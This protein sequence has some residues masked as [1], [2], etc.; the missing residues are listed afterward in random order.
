MDEQAIKVE[1]SCVHNLKAVSCILPHN[2]LYCLTGVSG[3]GK[4]SF[5]FDTIFVEGQRRYIESLSHQAKRLFSSLPKPD[6]ESITGLT[7]TIS[8]EQKSISHNPR[9]TVGTLTEIYDYLRILFAR[10]AI[11]YC[12]ISL[13]PVSHQTKDQVLLH[14]Y[15]FLQGEKIIILAPWAKEKRGLLEDDFEQIQKKGF[16]RVRIDGKVT[17]IDEIHDLDAEKEHDLEVVIDRIQVNEENKN[18]ALESFSTALEFGNGMM[19]LVNLESEEEHLFSIHA[20]SQKSGKSYPPLEPIDFSFN[21][22]S[23]MCPECHGLGQKQLFILDKVLDETASIRED[24][25][26]IASSYNTVRYKNIYDNLATLYNFSVDTPFSSLPDL[27]K[28]V[29][30]Y[31]TEKKWTRMLFIH[32]QTGATWH[33]TVQWKGVLNE[34][35]QRYQDAT[36]DLFKQKFERLMTLSSCPKCLGSR[37]KPYPACAQFFG[38]TVQEIVSMTIGEA[39]LFFSSLTLIGDQKLLAQ[40]I[41]DNVSSRLHFLQ[42]VGLSYITL[43]RSSPTLSGGEA[44]RVR[45]ASHIGSG[46]M[47][48]TYVLDEPSIGL[49]PHDNKKLIDSLLQLRDKGNTVIVVEHDEETMRA[50]DILIEFGPNAGENG[51]EIL[52]FGEIQELQKTPFS[53]T[54]EY[55][56]GK[57]IGLQRERSIQ[58]SSKQISLIGASHNNLKKVTVSIPL[59]FFVGVTGLSGSGKSSLF[60]ETL[61]PALSNHLNGSELRVGAYQSIQ[62]IESLSKIIQI[63]QSPIGRTPRSN[64]ATYSKVFDDIR[65][66]FASLPE[67]KA[68]GWN[69]GRFSFNVKEGSCSECAGMGMIRVEMDFLEESW[70][71]CPICLGERFDSETLSVRYR[72]KNIQEVLDMTSI[73]ALQFFHLLPNIKKKLEIL[74]DVGLDYLKLGQSSTTISGGEAQRLKLA[75]EL[76]RPDTGSTLYLLDEPTTGLHFRDIEHLLGILQRLVDRGNSVVVIEHNMDL[77]AQCDWVID[78][79]PESGEKGGRS[80]LKAQ[81]RCSHKKRALL[82]LRYLSI[83]LSETSQKRRKMSFYLIKD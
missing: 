82:E 78:L 14:A 38:K 47:G 64:P 83:F 66:L 80:Y 79:G 81:C 72:G 71:D 51:G 36:S 69:P 24:C 62:G 56:F 40:E 7:P 74:C 67:S 73:Q 15:R 53:H 34:A 4:S 39:H 18:R 48:I 32:P 6:A 25:C 8:I 58:K 57:G 11:A 76:A 20:F 65:T 35:Y 29:F 16:S 26:S 2:R 77:I 54:K 75:K 46:L 31:G 28:E 3:S 45:L 37:L 30:L 5:A 22:P 68:R 17:K 27:A 41:L 10:M 59:G 55:L 19:I 70:I 21:S 23:G 13:E 61:F 43:D 52:F 12:P 44:Q 1:H 60:L 33:D 9:S 49:H 63:D 42:E 50:A